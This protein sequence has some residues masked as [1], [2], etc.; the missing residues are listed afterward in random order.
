LAREQL[1]RIEVDVLRGDVSAARGHAHA[2]L[3]TGVQATTPQ[4]LFV[5]PLLM[6]IV[7]RLD[8]AWDES[9]ARLEEALGGATSGGNRELEG[10]ARAELALALLGRS[11]LDRAEEE[12][13]TAVEV[14]HTK[15]CRPDEV[16]AHLALAHTQLRPADGAALARAEQALVRAQELIEEIGARAFQP[17]VHEWRANVA[18]LRG[19]ASTAQRATETARRLYAAM[20]ATVQVERLFEER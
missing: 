7:H 9:I 3:E 4:S 15:R 14:A 20:G 17:E 1:P 16:R 6:G 12:A 2:A 10:W 8:S 13:R 18:R 11:A 5:G 19:D